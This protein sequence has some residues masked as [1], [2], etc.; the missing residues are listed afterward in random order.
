MYNEETARRYRDTHKD[1]IIEYMKK[2]REGV[3]LDKVKMDKVRASRKTWN[4]NNK[5]KMRAHDII[6][7]EIVYGRLKRLPCEVCGEARSQAHH[8]DY[9]KPLEVV[10]LCQTHHKQ[11]HS[12]LLQESLVMV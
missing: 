10:W 9:S 2:Y 5:D 11:L 1:K 7:K 12:Q 4:E 6:E 8:P 3:S